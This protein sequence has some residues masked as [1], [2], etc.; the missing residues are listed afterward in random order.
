MM[1]RPSTSSRFRLEASASAAADR[2]E[3]DRVGRA[4]ERHRRVGDRDLARVIGR[5]A[6]EP[7]LDLE[8][9]KAPPIE[10]G[11]QPLDL[12]HDFRADAVAGKE[13]KLVGCHGPH[14]LV[15][16][17]IP[18]GLLIGKPPL[19]KMRPRGRDGGRA[20]VGRTATVSGMRARANRASRRRRSVN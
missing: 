5:P 3:D 19:D 1:S 12:G 8:P 18:R 6:D 20:G 14:L 17:E 9:G 15:R 16:V 7:F 2:A 13:K 4:G 10:P 11:D